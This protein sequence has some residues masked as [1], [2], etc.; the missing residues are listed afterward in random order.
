MADIGCCA[1]IIAL[2]TCVFYSI[3][4]WVIRKRRECFDVFKDTGIPGPP[5]QSL[6]SGNADSFWKPTQ[7]ESLQQWLKKYGDV[8]RFFLGAVPIVV[9]KDLDMVK[10]ISVKDFSNFDARGHMMRMYE[11]QSVFSGNVLFSKGRVWREMRNCMAQFFTPAKLKMVVPS[12]LDAQSQFI[13]ELSVNAENGA[14]LEIGSYCEQFTFDVISK[15]AFGI[16]TGVQRNPQNTL[17]QTAVATS[18]DNLDGFLY[19]TCLFLYQTCYKR[20]VSARASPALG[21]RHRRRAVHSGWLQS[22]H[23][24]SCWRHVTQR[25]QMRRQGRSSSAVLPATVFAAYNECNYVTFSENLQNWSWLLKAALKLM[26]LFIK[27]SF[28]E[29]TDKA[30]AVIEFR[31]QNPEVNRPDMAQILLDHKLGRRGARAKGS[32]LRDPEPCTPVTMD[33]IA[34][35]CTSIFLAGYDTTRLA[36]TYWFY[37]MGKHPDVQE[38]MREEVLNA[39]KLEGDHLSTETLT[40]LSYTNQVISE[41]LRLYPPVITITT[42][43]AEDDWR[44]GR[45]LI[46][47]GTSVMVPVYQLHRDP[48]Y[49]VDPD[50]FDPDR[51]SPENRHLVN[52]LAY[53]PFGI[54]HRVCIGQRLALLELASVAAQVIRHFRILL[55]PSQKPHLELKTIA[56]LAVPRDD[57]W[58]QV[59]KLNAVI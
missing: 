50:K 28:A 57:V 2:V 17:F 44:H 20:I 53:Q 21:S 25:G 49:W 54:G 46:K 38:R 37:L 26:S 30:T 12:L 47:K 5:I 4:W 52:L 7:I 15:A 29:M 41:T 14:E 11:L 51:F 31:R 19:H 33:A 10:E 59:Q 58:I 16:D 27:N 40:S 42:R 6:I 43:R 55:G 8:F 18:Q 32:E 34:A 48:L 39:Y 1:W 23:W 36:L 56:I 3:G 22:S 24:Q 13:D 35:N 45:Y 9:V